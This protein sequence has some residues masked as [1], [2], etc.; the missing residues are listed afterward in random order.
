MHFEFFYIIF[1]VSKPRDMKRSILITVILFSSL[2]MVAQNSTQGMEFWFSYMENGYKYNGSV[3]GWVDNTVMIS[4]KRAC[5][6]SISK[7]D[8]SLPS[9][10]F[11]VGNN[12]ITTITIPEAYAYNENNSEEVGNKSLVLRATDTVSVYLSNI[13]TYSF[14]ASFVLPVESLGSEYIIQCFDQ[15]VNDMGSGLDPNILTSAFLI[16]AVEDSTLIDITPS[17]ITEYSLAFPGTTTTIAL[18]A[19]ETYFVRSNYEDDFRDLSGTVIMVHDG[20]KVAVFNGNTTT[21]IPVDVGN[22]RD[23]VF[24]QALPVDSWGQQFAVTTS[25]GR[26]RDFVK[27]T[28]SGDGNTVKRNGQVIATLSRGESFV[29]D[30]YASDGSCFIETSLP[31]VVYLFN[32]TGEEPMEP[33]GS[34]NGDPSMAW[35]PPVEQRI[36][37]ITFCTFDSEYEFAS[38]DTHHVNIVVESDDVGNV[39][40]DGALINASD[41]HPVRG[42]SDYSYVRKSISHGTHHLSCETGLIAY[43]YGFGQARGY[44]YC[45]GAN[46]ISLKQKLI[47]NG[48]WS[49]FYP[50]GLYMCNT[51]DA[52]FTVETNYPINGVGWTFGDGQT[53]EGIEV[54]HQYAS[55][56]DY[57]ATA[58]VNG[59]N[60]FSLESVYDTLSVVIHVGEPAHYDETHSVCDVDV[61]N[62]YG[63]EYSQ[64]GYYENV[65]TSIYGCDSTYILTLDMEFTPNFEFV[66]THWPIGGSE[67]HISVNEYAIRPLEPRTR[68]DTVL[69]KIDCP[70]WY[71]EPHGSNG[72]ECTLYIHSYLLEPVTL[73]AWAINRCDTIHEEF[74]I[75]TS[76]YDVEE[77]VERDGFA[78]APNPT[79]GNM[80][81]HFDEGQG[82]C[83]VQV[84]NAQGQQM[85]SFVLDLDQHREFAYVMPECRNGLYYFVIKCEGRTMTQK[86]MLSR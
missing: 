50:H 60:E 53:G 29:F 12:G 19:G 81:L 11:T 83:E 6:G 27:I 86:I 37:E 44:A 8:G 57:V 10:P 67:T 64:S 23:H 62:Y 17:I 35:I 9:I 46:V 1:A 24:E 63:L 33:I 2:F 68:V 54:S 59:T 39:Y 85:D 13:A 3:A 21:C 75:Q 51:E 80:V 55:A 14:D 36:N 84:F 78:V 82:M 43:V 66:G 25:H 18:N 15:E 5:T 58:Y 77:N 45:V 72:R 28:S 65:G 61:F 79:D 52:D 38:I 41:F 73:H 30:L 74:F 42:T 71:V 26:V 49:E 34:N 48:E 47:V 31:S 40:F 7:P 56:G 4:A 32:T 76:Y 16:V 22:G 69:W 20:K 70:N